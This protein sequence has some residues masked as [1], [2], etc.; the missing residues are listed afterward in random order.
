MIDIISPLTRQ[1]EAQVT[2]PRET[3]YHLS[4]VTFAY[5]LKETQQ[6][7]EEGRLQGSFSHAW[8]ASGEQPW[9]ELNASKDLHSLEVG[10][11]AT[12]IHGH[13][14]K[15]RV[16]LVA[17]AYP[18]LIAGQTPG[19]FMLNVQAFYSHFGLK[20]AV[21]DEGIKDEPDH[22]VTMLEFCALLCHLELK[23]LVGGRDTSTFRR[24]QRDFLARYLI[25]MLRILRGTYAK[26]S[27]YELDATLAYLITVLPDW[28]SAQHRALEDQVG[29]SSKSTTENTSVASANQSMWT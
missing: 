17:S 27:H 22:V 19:A 23:A 2:E 3:I 7:L 28:A 26:E 10:Y 8:V 12:F 9:P 16:P 5:P 21:D 25:P 20:A 1:R 14:G 4:A 15:P 11:M 29:P 24:A 13:R 6:A 18:Q